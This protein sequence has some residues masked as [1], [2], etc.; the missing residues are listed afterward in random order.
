MIIGGGFIG[1]EVAASARALDVEVTVIEILPRLLAR[2][3]PAEIANRLQRR[4]EAAGVRCLLD[5]QVNDIGRSERGVRLT[6]GDGQSIEADAVL[7]G[8][9]AAPRTQL[10]EAAGL[11]VDR[12]ILVDERMRTSDPWIFAAG[13]VTACPHPLGGEC[14]RLES[15]ENAEVQGALAARNMLDAGEQHAPLPWF[16]TDQYEL[17]L[18]ISGFPERATKAIK[19]P[20]GADGC[21]IFHLTPDDTLIAVSGLGPP[22]FVKDFKISQKLLEHRAAID[23]AAL[24]EP[25]IPLKSLLRA[26]NR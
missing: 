11:A 8:I 3:V 25:R 20:A 18:Q 26:S 14:L 12:G 10:A 15:W 16:W 24:A 2:I 6:L 1:L 5:H 21:L 22:S 17:S 13:D 7:F 19:R 4:H 9:G 23:V